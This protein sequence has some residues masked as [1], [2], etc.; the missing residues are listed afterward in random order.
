MNEILH[1]GKRLKFLI[2]TSPK[3]SK[4]I[5]NSMNY[6]RLQGLAYYYRQPFIKK[7][8]LYKF[9]ETLEISENE[10]YNKTTDYETTQTNTIIAEDAA[11]YVSNKS[12]HQGKNLKRLLEHRFIN[13]SA[14][15]DALQLNRANF[16]SY[17]KEPTLPQWLILQV[18]TILEIPAS[19]IT[20]E[21]ITE[22]KFDKLVYDQL[23]QIQ[24]QLSVLISK[25]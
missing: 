7:D 17:F 6:K 1:E 15:C 12:Y 13:I 25:V 22:K 20:G 21:N 9:L 4:E 24:K 2:K 11:T 16:Y 10:F 14:M 23:N 5:A 19:K 18:C 3:K 8:T